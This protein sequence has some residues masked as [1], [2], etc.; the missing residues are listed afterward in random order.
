MIIFL[1]YEGFEL[2]ANAG[3]DV[4]HPKVL[5]KAFYTSVAVVITVYVLIAVI[6]VGTLPYEKVGRLETMPWPSP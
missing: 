6:T 1:A 5:E 4:E 2:I 3:G